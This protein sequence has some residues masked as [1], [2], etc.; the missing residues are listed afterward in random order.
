MTNFVVSV[1]LCV[2]FCFCFWFLVLLR[3]EHP[4]GWICAHYKS[5]Y[6][7]YYYLL[8]LYLLNH[9]LKLLSY[10]YEYSNYGNYGI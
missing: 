5:Y 8:L 4:A 9:N 7:Y 10:H 6:Y 2:V 3:L 1:F